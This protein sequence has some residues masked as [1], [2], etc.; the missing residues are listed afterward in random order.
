MQRLSASPYQTRRLNP[1]SDVLPFTVLD[2]TVSTV[3]GLTLQQLFEQGRLFYADYRDQK[4]LTSSGQFAAAC[5]AYFYIDVDS[6]DF[7]PLAIRT[8][9]GANLIY[10]PQDSPND[11]LLA[12]IMYSANDFWF[13][14]W[15]HLAGTHEVVQIVWEAAIRSISQE[16]PVYA[17]LDRRKLP[18]RGHVYGLGR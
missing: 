15:N 18:Q 11:W 10:T 1:G 5:D 9:V 2:T 4:N 8:N 7:L 17:I 3:S 16:H 6:G 13:A 12:K 14:Q